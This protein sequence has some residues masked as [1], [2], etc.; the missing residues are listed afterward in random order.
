MEHL[1]YIEKVYRNAE[2]YEETNIKRLGVTRARSRQ[3]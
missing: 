2:Q 3:C 1:K